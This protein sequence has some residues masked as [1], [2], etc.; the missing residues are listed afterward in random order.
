MASVPDPSANAAP[1]GASPTAVRLL[2][3]VARPVERF[4][5]VQAASGIVLLVMAAVALV[6]SNSPWA[7]SYE[8]LWHTSVGIHIGALDLRAPL[9]FVVNDMLMVVFF[10]L[11]GLEIRREMHGGELSN[12]RR[13]ALPFFAALGGMLVP[14]LIYWGVNPSGPTRPGWG[15][16]MATDI[17]FAVGVLALLGNRVPSGLRVLLLALAIID[18]IGAIVVIAVFYSSG[19]SIVGF[20]IAAAGIALVILLQRLG[21]RRAIAYIPAGIVLW[22]GLLRAGVHPTIAGVILGLLTPVQ[23]WFGS[24]RFVETAERTVGM[25]R[26]ASQGS[27]ERELLKPLQDLQIARRETV[28]P[29]GTLEATLHPWVAFGIMPLFA[30]ANAGV[31]LSSGSAVDGDTI[32]MIGVAAGLVFGKPIGVLLGCLAAIKLGLGVLPRRV[33]LPGLLLVGLVAGIGFTMAIFVAN[34]A[35]PAE[36]PSAHYLAA[37]K[38]GVL[39]GSGIAAIAAL[40]AGRLLLRA[41]TADAPK[42]VTPDEAERSTED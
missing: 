34:L 12:L 32:V 5:H 10:F 4:L 18:D 7:A 31:N 27:D 37:A 28:S 38:I 15:I 1:P 29:L 42:D 21:V 20:A 2:G 25:V 22:V 33:T 24:K 9:H 17:A 41:P 3:R 40:L 36:S 6:W 14:A 30:L 39:C 19:V 16:P 13:A 23:A 26:A 11:V 35:F 8:H